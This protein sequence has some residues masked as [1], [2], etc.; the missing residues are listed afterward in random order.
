MSSEAS[1]KAEQEQLTVI[2]IDWLSVVD[3]LQVE[4]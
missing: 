4:I 3:D 2:W 1:G